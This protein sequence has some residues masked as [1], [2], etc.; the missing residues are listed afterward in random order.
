MV[1]WEGAKVLA[2]ARMLDILTL[3]AWKLVLVGP[4]M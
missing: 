1:L 3:S 4:L 2:W